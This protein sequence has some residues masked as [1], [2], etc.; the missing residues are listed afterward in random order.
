MIYLITVFQ[1]LP[2]M[3]K[4]RGAS[5]QLCLIMDHYRVSPLGLL[6][7]LSNLYPRDESPRAACS[8]YPRGL[9]LAFIRPTWTL[10]VCKLCRLQES[11]CP[12]YIIF[13]RS[14]DVKNDSGF[15]A[16]AQKI[17]N[18]FSVNIALEAMSAKVLSDRLEPQR[19]Q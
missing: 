13:V 18:S 17:R 8:Q 10:S 11:K 2:T 19:V 7:C 3:S 5:T 15:C 14:F 16:T 1:C 9:S 12:L 6:G 4:Q